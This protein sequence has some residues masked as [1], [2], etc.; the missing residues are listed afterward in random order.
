MKLHLQNQR[1]KIPECKN[2][3]SISLNDVPEDNLDAH[4]ENILQ[5]V[6]SLKDY[7]T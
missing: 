1:E 7:E 4:M 5:R 2:C 3:E 6:N